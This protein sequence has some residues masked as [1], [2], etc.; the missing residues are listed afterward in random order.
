MSDL[1]ELGIEPVSTALAGGLYHP[2]MGE[3]WGGL[4]ISSLI[5]FIVF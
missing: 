2:A 3:A 1:P 5:S 4:F